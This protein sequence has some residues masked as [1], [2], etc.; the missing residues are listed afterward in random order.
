MRN[1]YQ[2]IFDH[3]NETPLSLYFSSIEKVA[4]YLGKNNNF[5]AYEVQHLIK[6]EFIIR[7]EMSVYLKEPLLEYTIAV[8]KLPVI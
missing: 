2:V 8:Y 1:I 3:P 4:K 5:N 7:N 6:K